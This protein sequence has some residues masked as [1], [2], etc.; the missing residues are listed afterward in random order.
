MEKASITSQ[1]I[2]ILDFITGLKEIV[3]SKMTSPSNILLD[4]NVINDLMH[5]KGIE[6]IKSKLSAMN[7][8]VDKQQISFEDQ[9]KHIMVML[10]YIEAVVKRQD[11]NDKHAL[12]VNASLNNADES[13]LKIYHHMLKG[14]LYFIQHQV[15]KSVFTDVAANINVTDLIVLVSYYMS[16]NALRTFILSSKPALGHIEKQADGELLNLLLQYINLHKSKVNS[17]MREFLNASDLSS[18]FTSE[19]LERLREMLLE[20]K[21]KPTADELEGYEAFFEKLKDLKVIVKSLIGFGDRVNQFSNEVLGN[22]NVL[23]DFYSTQGENKTFE[24]NSDTLIWMDKKLDNIIGIKKDLPTR[25]EITEMQDAKLEIDSYYMSLVEFYEELSGAVRVYIRTKDYLK[26]DNDWLSQLVHTKTSEVD[27]KYKITKNFETNRILVKRGY[28]EHTF[29]PFFNVIPSGTSNFQIVEDRLINMENFVRLF[30]KQV[31]EGN[32]KRLSLVFF[33]YGASGS[34]KTYTLFNKSVSDKNDQG[35]L[36]SMKEIFEKNGFVI[37]MNGYRQI[38]GYLSDG[39]FIEKPVV[40]PDVDQFKESI[41]SH[42]DKFQRFLQE[43]LDTKILPSG[44]E[45]M[46]RFDKLMRSKGGEDGFIK[47]TPNNPQSSRGFL[48]INFDVYPIGSSISIGKVGFVDMAG[49]EDPYDLLVRLCPTF[50][51]PEENKLSFL[52]NESAQDTV[53]NY[54]ELD[55]VYHRVQQEVFRFTEI[56]LFFVLHIHRILNSANKESII[57]NVQTMAAIFQQKYILLKEGYSLTYKSSLDNILLDDLISSIQTT[58]DN[59][60]ERLKN[61]FNDRNGLIVERMQK[62]FAK[63]ATAANKKKLDSF[64]NVAKQKKQAVNEQNRYPRFPE[65]VLSKHKNSL[66]EQTETIFDVSF[67]D[68]HAS[69]NTEIGIKIKTLQSRSMAPL[70]YFAIRKEMDKIMSELIT[71]SIIK[72]ST[73]PEFTAGD[74]INNETVD[75]IQNFIDLVSKSETQNI[76][77]KTLAMHCEKLLYEIIN[78]NGI[79]AKNEIKL[80]VKYTSLLKYLSEQ[81]F[82]ASSTSSL[83]VYFNETLV[84]PINVMNIPNMSVEAGKA[85]ASMFMKDQKGDLK[86][87]DYSEMLVHF[88]KSLLNFMQNYFEESLKHVEIEGKSYSFPQKYLLRIIQEGFYINQANAELVEY[89]RQRKEDKVT[90]NVALDTCNLKDNLASFSFEKYDKF[91]DLT[92]NSENE[93][94]CKRYTQIVS[95]LRD[96]FE[97]KDRGEYAKYI[98]LCNIRR[99]SDTKYRMGAIDT[100]R[101]VNKLKST[102]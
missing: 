9:L 8:N 76:D 32:E 41:S 99:E 38:Y 69:K 13:K 20:L 100:L 27:E 17:R 36:Y 54:G 31:V 63:A 91:N 18:D 11:E 64:D 57:K 88:R 15:E 21:D 51:W 81:Q 68:D 73:Q 92:M 82:K 84:L 101:L 86:K 67:M 5:N 85:L 29:G 23:I 61:L 46:E 77:E 3:N 50:V 80:I 30:K 45:D 47:P 10:L 34:G 66:Q 26:D 70:I 37:R 79:K 97:N 95:T 52:K 19:D 4:T 7:R 59:V 48:I 24:K 40:P 94:H 22:T 83:D 78:N 72:Q 62:T 49:N 2:I 35:I 16:L 12:D 55:V 28:E 75:V 1:N 60:I 25:S 43:K 96:L 39:Q 65:L 90:E 6:A 74:N 53:I 89:L 93:I 33:T 42:E 44:P 14:F 56:I 58:F 87:D 98:M 71:S 102:G